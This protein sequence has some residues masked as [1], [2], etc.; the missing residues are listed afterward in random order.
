[1]T[2]WPKR[3]SQHA[4]LVQRH[5]QA[6]RHAADE[7]RP[8]GA[9]VD[10][11]ARG[12]DAEQPRHPDLAGVGVHP[13]LGELR[14]EGVAAWSVVR[15]RPGRR[16]RRPRR[17]RPGR[18]P[19]LA[20]NS[21]G[22]HDE[23]RAPGGGARRPPATD[24]DRAAGCRRS[25][26]RRRPT[27]HA[28]R[29]GGDLRQH[30]P[31]AG[32]DVGGADLD[33]VPA[34][35]EADGRRRRRLAQSSGRS[36]RRRRCR[37]A[38]RPRRRAGAAAAPR[39]AE[40]LGALAQALDEVPARPRLA[41]SRGRPPARCGSRSSTG[42]MPQRTASSSMA[43]SGANMPGHS[44]GARIHDGTG[45]SSGG[46]PVGGAPVRRG[47]HHP[48]RD[49]GLLGELLDPRGLLDH[50]VAI[51]VQPAV[52]V[53]AEPDPLD[54]R[55][56][57]AG[58][59]EHLLPGQR[60]LHRPAGQRPA[61]PARPARRWRAAVPLE[62]K[63]PPTYGA[64]HPDL[65][66]RRARRPRPRAGRDAV[67]ALGGV[68]QGQRHV[69]RPGP[70]AR[71]VRVRLHRVVVLHRR[72]VGLRR[73]STAA[74]G[75][76]RVDVALARCRSRMPGLTLLGRVEVV[77][78]RRA[79]RCRAAARRRSPGTSVGGLPG[80][81]RRSRRR[82]RRR[83]GPRKATS[84][85]LQDGELAG[86]RSSASRGAL[87]VGRAPRSTP[88]A[89]PRPRRRRSGD[90]AAG[91]R[92]LHR[93]Q[94][95][96][97]LDRRA[98]RRTAPCRAPCAA[99]STAGQAPAPIGVA[100]LAACCRSSR[101]PSGAGRAASATIVL[102]ASG[103]LNPLPPSAGLRRAAAAR[104]R[105]PRGTASSVARPPRSS[106]SARVARHGLCAT[107]PSAIRTSRDG[108]VRRRRARRRRRPARR[109]TTPGRAPCGRPSGAP[110]GSGGRST[111]VI[112]SPC[113]SVVSRGGSSPGSR[114][115]SAS[116]TVRSPSGA[117]H[118]HDA[119]RARPAR[120]PCPRGGD[121]PTQCVGGAED[122]VVAACSRR[123]AEQ[124]V[125]G[126]RLLHG[127][128]TSWK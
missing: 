19:Y 68:A 92:R 69:G 2:T 119:R 123:R 107:P 70:T 28:E 53:G 80:D 35:L 113:A 23:R 45:T 50:V 124:P 27:S 105:R 121:R 91:D 87:S 115:S 101:S 77:A 37:P 85:G 71:V 55:R 64:D 60:Q 104:R 6:H 112:S 7:L 30:R 88:V 22:G 52:G 62:P 89:A 94:V 75:Q 82:P 73:P 58:Q 120:P 96:G 42:S 14:A 127:V 46:Q 84:V 26:R 72:R 36:R 114:C 67:H 83:A 93:V 39:P 21:R 95:G 33:D 98:R 109:R 76:R 103:T 99:P 118:L 126:S 29:V 74:V 117:E 31:G 125:P 10:D 106:S 86:R 18:S 48:G 49:A 128:V 9:R 40:P 44:P 25:A 3:G 79:A 111:A 97:L 110:A 32:A 57:V 81:L 16:R 54:G 20:R 8:R 100:G 108:A 51:A 116:G 61:R 90:P 11:P 38:S 15:R 5:R 65:L 102:R 43:T 78:V 13:H 17:R 66:R 1:M 41:R 4:V 24:G 59:R 12:E 122:R 34:V 47:V 56:A 63:P